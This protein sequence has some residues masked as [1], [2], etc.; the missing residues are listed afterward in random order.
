VIVAG[1]AG[2]RFAP[3][4][5]CVSMDLTLVDVTDVPECEVGDE[6]LLI[7]ERDRLRITAEDL[8]EQIGTISYEIACGI[9]ARV[10]RIY[11]P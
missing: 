5:G 11:I 1:R 6:V 10:P 2:A 4:I 9:S 8:A 7:G 3:I